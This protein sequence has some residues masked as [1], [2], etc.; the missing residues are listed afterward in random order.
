ML[1]LKT[2]ILVLKTKLD[3]DTWWMYREQDNK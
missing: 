3:I 2:E 1:C